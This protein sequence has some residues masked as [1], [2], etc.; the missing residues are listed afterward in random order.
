[1]PFQLPPIAEQSRIVARV[2]ELRRH[3]ADLRQRLA[4]SQSTRAFLATAL[5]EQV[6]A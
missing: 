3:C 4:A 5:V 1:M 2:T 6:L